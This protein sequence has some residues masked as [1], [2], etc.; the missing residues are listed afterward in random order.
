[1]V[2]N[3]NTKDYWENRFESGDWETKQGRRQTRLFAETQVKYLK[4]APN[5]SGVILD[6]GCGLGDAIPVYRSSFPYATLIGMDI[7]QA[8]I[9]SCRERYGSLAQFI[10][11]SYLDVPKVDIIIASNIFEHLSDDITVANH[12][13]AKCYDLFIITPYRE[14]LTPGAEHVNSYDIDSFSTLRPLEYI[15]FHSQGWGAQRWR[16]WLIQCPKNILRPFFGKQIV[17]RQKQIM[18]HF[19]NWLNS[20]V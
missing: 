20:E 12:L 11:G 19:V 2:M 15:V 10:Q 16:F 1:M 17:R 6:F 4:I 7:S 14:L 5:F 18:F 13:L 3:I 9:S 8:A